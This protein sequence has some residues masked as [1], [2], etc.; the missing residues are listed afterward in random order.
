M[1]EITTKWPAMLITGEKVTEK[2]AMDIIIRT[3][4]A[5]VNPN[6]Y[7]FGNNQ[8]FGKQWAKLIDVRYD[9]DESVY[10]RSEC[11]NFVSLE[12]LYNNLLG[13]CW[14]GGSTSWIWEDG[15]I[16]RFSN[17]GKWPSTEKVFD[18][19][20]QIAQA[21]PYLKLKVTLFDEQVMPDF[22]IRGQKI[23]YAEYED[24]LD[25]ALCS[26]TVENGKV[27]Y[28]NEPF[29]DHFSCDLISESFN[30]KN[31]FISECYV[32]IEFLEKL[33]EEVVKRLSKGESTLDWNNDHQGQ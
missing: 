32:S 28:H 17:I 5:V 19:L 4:E 13:S 6:M 15:S 20:K 23:V 29:K 10:S 9:Y 26:F 8:D 25:K 27:T 33:R 21:F 2:Q 3:D 1:K 14:V 30:K 16:F 7:T 22:Y 12:Y 18:E 31:P 24:V 11:I